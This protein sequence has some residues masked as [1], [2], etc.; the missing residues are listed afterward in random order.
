[1][2]AAGDIRPRPATPS[3]RVL[4][5]RRDSRP[6]P[7]RDRH[8]LGDTGYDHGQPS[9]FAC[10][11]RTWGR[12]KARTIPMI[13]DHEY[14]VVAGGTAPG[15]AS[16]PTSTTSS[17]RTG[18]RARSV[19]GLLQLRPRGLARRRP[20]LLLLLP[21]RAWLRHGLG[22][23]VRKRPERTRAIAPGHLARDALE[24]RQHPRRLLPHAA[25]LGDGLRPW[26]RAR[27]QR[28]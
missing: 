25:I 4:Y 26:G 11:D 6:E 22:A 16:S 19:E 2:L 27:P 28:Q 7:E 9:D 3:S 12:A 24:L 8:P 18:I 5:D 21:G 10:Y 14:D 17:R 13:G 20:Q 23:L 1:M 15:S